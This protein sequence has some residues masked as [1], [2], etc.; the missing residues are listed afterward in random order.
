MLRE[1]D[2]G[3]VTSWGGLGAALHM[4]E[5][6]SKSVMPDSNLL[7]FQVSDELKGSEDRA[8]FTEEIPLFSCESEVELCRCMADLGE[9]AAASIWAAC[10]K[11]GP[12]IPSPKGG[13]CGSTRE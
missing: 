13:C 12:A 1:G 5:V 11:G 8:L 7:Y 10:A 2:G 9:D 6:P 3:G 4:L